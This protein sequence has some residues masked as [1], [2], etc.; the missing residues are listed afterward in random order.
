MGR[1]RVELGIHSEVPS[2]YCTPNPWR[3]RGEVASEC[4]PLVFD[5]DPAVF[6][7][8]AWSLLPV[9][10]LLRERALGTATNDWRLLDWR[11]QQSRTQVRDRPI[12]LPDNARC[13]C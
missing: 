1:N 6:D 4:S 11:G 9:Q 5:E 8:F 2:G 7:G 13:C 3:R 12:R 10:Y